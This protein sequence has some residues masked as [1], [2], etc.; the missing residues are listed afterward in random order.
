MVMPVAE[1][2]D[3]HGSRLHPFPCA[4]P[5]RRDLW[6]AEVRRSPI[7]FVTVVKVPNDRMRGSRFSSCNMS[8]TYCGYGCLP[9][10]YYAHL[11]SRAE[12]VA[13]LGSFV[14]SYPLFGF[15]PEDY[16]ELFVEQLDLVLAIRE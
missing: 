15:R 9:R 16:D 7:A 5:P 12:I 4:R 2:S 3:G 14:E 11:I 8:F 13:G 1:R 6:I 10:L